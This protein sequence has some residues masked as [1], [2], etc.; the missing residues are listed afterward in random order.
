[1]LRLFVRTS[2]LRVAFASRQELHGL[3]IVTM[4]SVSPQAAVDAS[5]P[6]LT[7]CPPSTGLVAFLT[8]VFE[9]RRRFIKRTI[10]NRRVKDLVK[11]ALD[12]LEDQEIDYHSDPVTTREP[13]IVPTQLRDQILRDEHS[14]VDRQR[15]WE[16]VRKVVETN[17]NVRTNLEEVKGE[18]TIVWRWV[19][20]ATPSARERRVSFHDRTTSGTLLKD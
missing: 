2:I 4:S 1:M 10:E 14:P 6:L 13:Y 11:E 5:L 3:R 17:A 20:N 16:K 7:G 19:G 15:V 12:T 18:D 8:G 9:L